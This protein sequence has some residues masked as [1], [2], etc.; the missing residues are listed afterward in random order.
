MSM[1]MCTPAGFGGG[2][3]GLCAGVGILRGAQSAASP[4]VFGEPEG[5]S[6]GPGQTR[7]QPPPLPQPGVEARRPGA[8]NISWELELLEISLVH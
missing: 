1:S 3:P 6:A 8:T 7:S 4:A 5:D 2:F